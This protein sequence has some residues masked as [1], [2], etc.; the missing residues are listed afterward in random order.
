VPY[1][2][3]SVDDDAAS[4]RILVMLIAT[5]ERLRIAGLA[6]NGQEALDRVRDQCPDAIICDLQMPTLDG[7]SAIPQL[8]V[9]CPDTVIAVYSAGTGSELCAA[10]DLG[11]DAAFDKTTLDPARLLDQVTELCHNK[12]RD[13]DPAN[14]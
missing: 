8:R 6:S 4:Q 2:V 7:L 3:L 9:A 14:G 11:A 5:D 13:S 10:I 12:R 1:S